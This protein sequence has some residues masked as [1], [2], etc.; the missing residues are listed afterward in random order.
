MK[1]QAMLDSALSYFKSSQAMV[2]LIGSFS[3]TGEVGRVAVKTT[4]EVTVGNK[5]ISMTK[6]GQSTD[7]YLEMRH[8]DKNQKTF[9]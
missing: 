1:I 9:T 3:G 4:D 5:S 6:R 2:Q 7:E 8:Q